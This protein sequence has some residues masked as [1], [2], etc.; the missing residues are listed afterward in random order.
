M[1]GK[2]MLRVVPDGPL[3]CVDDALFAG[4]SKHGDWD[5][6]TDKDVY[7]GAILRHLGK[8]RAGERL[9][10]QDGHHHLAA[11]IVRCLQLLDKES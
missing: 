8:W 11:V 2:M 1:P 6:S 10:Q 7:V 9:D 4:V 3:R 5:S